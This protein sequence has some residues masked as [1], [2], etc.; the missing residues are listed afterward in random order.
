MDIDLLKF[1][2]PPCATA[3]LLAVVS[4]GDEP[5]GVEWVS[6]RVGWCDKAVRSALKVLVSNGLIVRVHYRGW[7]ASETAVEM[8]EKVI[9]KH[10]SKRN[11]SVSNGTIPFE[12]ERQTVSGT[13]IYDDLYIDNDNDQKTLVSWLQSHGFVDAPRW[14][15]TVNVPLVNMWRTWHESLPPALKQKYSNIGGLVRKSVEEGKQPDYSWRQVSQVSID[16]RLKNQVPEK[17]KDIV[18]S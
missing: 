18:K 4:R 15:N 12:T 3:V 13:Y 1:R 16:E 9:H 14:V 8:V 10:C 11:N 17:Y 5:C 2:H 6:D 7:V